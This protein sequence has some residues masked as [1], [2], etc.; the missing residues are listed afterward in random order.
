MRRTNY[1][2]CK[3]IYY[4]STIFC[5]YFIGA[6]FVIYD[7]N[8]VLLCC[9]ATIV[10]STPLTFGYFKNPDI[11]KYVIGF[12]LEICLTVYGFERNNMPYNQGTY[13]AIVCLSSLHLDKKL[14]ISLGAYIAVVYAVFFMLMP[15]H[16]YADTYTLRDVMLRLVTIYIGQA[17]L[18]VLINHIENQ[19]MQNEAK[20]L[21]AE[22]LLKIV[23]EKRLEA[24]S[25]TNAKSDFLANM[26]HEIRTPLNAIIGMTEIVLRSDINHRVRQN[27]LHIQNSSKSLLVIIN[28]I[29][30]F[31]KIESGRFEIILAP[32]QIT[33]VIYDCASIGKLRVQNRPIEFSVDVDKNLPTVLLGDEVRV[34]QI[35]LN[36]VTNATK[37]THSGRIVLKIRGEFLENGKVNL[38][39]S[40]ADTGV[41]I[42]G[43]DLGKLFSTFT[44]VDTRRNRLVEGSGLGLTI[45]K[46]LADLMQGSIGVSSEYGQGS[47]FFVCIPQDIVDVTPIGEFTNFMPEVAQA[48]FLPAFSASTAKV[49]VVDDNEVNIVV[50]QGLLEP[51]EMQLF[52]A[53]SAEECFDMIQHQAFDIIFMDHMM[54]AMDGFEAT[55]ILRER[56]V[57]TPIIALTANAI[58]GAREMYL[59]SGFDAYISKP[60]DPRELDKVLGAFLPAERICS[61]AAAPEQ[62]AP[63]PARVYSDEVMRTIY[64]EGKRKLPL[65]QKYYDV[66]DWQ[67]YT[68]E[69][70]AL[71]TCAHV[72]EHKELLGL[73]VEHEEAGRA[74][75]FERI[76]QDFPHLY[77]LYAALVQSLE[78]QYG[79]NQ[80]TCPRTSVSHEELVDVL[81]SLRHCAAAFDLDGMEVHLAKLKSVTLSAEQETALAAMDAALQRLDY[82]AVYEAAWDML[83]V[84]NS[85]WV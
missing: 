46:K 55:K 53:Y 6:N 59:A 43:E 23:E 81:N 3:I 32:Y 48:D 63:S 71:K 84:A 50:A 8:L 10:I 14:N 34:R 4:V 5:L 7:S 1:E 9:I 54:P 77:A 72:C 35:V 75:D 83:G 21:N 12:L 49:L 17:M 82:D 25:S 47:T 40:V 15:E 31:S 33:S 20:T 65:L 30:D 80:D 19:Q 41:G 29:L 44:Q 64:Q 13:L 69:V 26:S 73:A 58:A 2:K 27:M 61:P 76:V 67:S 66:A 70:H 62:P 16:L 56:G 36:F 18:L 39:M 37:F 22:T 11:Q 78:P 57:T 38:H 85:K 74:G 28:D 42:A 24:L 79:L 60:I 45:S 68:I 52:A 51:Y